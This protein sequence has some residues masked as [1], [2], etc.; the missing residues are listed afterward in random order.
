MREAR[1]RETGEGKRQERPQRPL[2]EGGTHPVSHVLRSD[3]WLQTWA[4]HPGPPE[5]RVPGE[6]PQGGAGAHAPSLAVPRWGGK[7]PG[8]WGPGQGWGGK[9]GKGGGHT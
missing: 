9:M 5:Q 7:S 6:G 4:A 3:P 8:S 1:G 2:Q